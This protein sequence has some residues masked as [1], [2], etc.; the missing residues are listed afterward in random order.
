MT[1]DAAKKH[2]TLVGAEADSDE[3]RILEDAGFTVQIIPGQ[4]ASS[5]TGLYEERFKMLFTALNDG[6]FLADII[7]DSDGI[8]NDY[9]YV[10]VNPAFG[11]MVGIGSAQIIGK[12]AS[13]LL[14]GMTSSW[15]DVFR[16][17]APTNISTRAEIYSELS[18]RN[19]EVFAFKS[20]EGQYAAFVSDITFRKHAEDD[21]HKLNRTLKA[22]SRSDKAMMHA[23]DESE[24]MNDV[25]KIIIEDCGHAMVWIA[26]AENDEA[27]SV[28]PVAQAGFEEGYLENLNI[29]WADTERGQ[30]PTGTAIRTGMPCICKNMVSD[31]KFAAWRTEALKRGYASSISL[32]LKTSGQTFGAI[33]I[34]ARIPD[35]FSEDEA[36][37]LNELASD[38]AY[39]ITAIRLRASHAE[40]EV[41]LR[42]SEQRLTSIINSINHPFYALD[43]EWRFVYL[44][45]ATEKSL[46]MKRDDLIGRSIWDFWTGVPGNQFYDNLHTAMNKRMEIEFESYSKT[47]NRWV[48]ARV[49]PSDEGLT[50]YLNDITERKKIEDV[51]LFLLQRGWSTTDEDFFMSLA[52]FLADALEMD[53]V[54]IDKLAGDHLSAQTVAIYNDGKFEDNVSYTLKDTP[55]GDVVSNSI[56]CYPSGVMHLFPNDEVLQEMKADS[57]IGTTLWSSSGEPIGLIAVIGCKP[58]ENTRLAEAILKLTSIRAAGEL[59][60]RQAEEKLNEASTLAEEK[61]AQLESFITSL[62]DGVI[63]FDENGQILFMNEAGKTIFGISES[64]MPGSWWTYQRYK[65]SPGKIPLDDT[66]LYQ[67]LAGEIVR[68]FRYKASMPWG[69]EVTVSVSAAPVRD[70]QD[71]IMG[72]TNV[73]RDIS[74]LVE[75]E[76][77]KE[78]IYKREHKIAQILQD[79]IMPAEV[80]EI[81]FGC[82]IAAMYRPAMDEAQIGGD[83][84]D[85]FDLGDGKFGVLIGDV[86]GKGLPAAMR[87]AAARYAVRSYAYTD[88]RPSKVMELSNNSLCRDSGDEAKI[89]TAL[90]AIINTRVGVITYA[91]AGHEPPV[92]QKNSG[93]CKA[94]DCGGVPFGIFQGAEYP[95]V[96]L[97]LDPGDTIVLITDGITEA[98]APGPVLFGNQRMIDV[99]EVNAGA[100]PKEI[101]YALIDAATDHAGG[102]LQDD[103]AIVAI[104]YELDEVST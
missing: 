44:N 72:A 78:E 61:A 58:L 81:M 73:F 59:E 17:V 1:E 21:L 70:K 34:Y 82:H 50:V 75:F 95:Q 12:T 90:F 23:V 88:I 15:L 87:V 85:I 51:Y 37:L 45:K 28:R 63:L 14:P 57:Y 93:E 25:C 92:I 53:Y 35:A 65:L 3:V 104:R 22:L 96:S 40:A 2:V 41:S 54:C 100:M 11:Q 9:R 42:L 66:S 33:M 83:F 101:V 7:Y 99:I 64:E 60:R 102:S 4:S 48:D 19:F 79:A 47:L 67:A 30:G 16:M 76:R 5:E 32:P 62:A 24:Y 89:L 98:R 68:D 31:P 103:A 52:R 49:F 77:K 94:L 97:R 6:F 38:L 29:T 86:T 18:H 36:G 56:C 74:D 43:N 84:Y 27:K 55:C 8:P 91:T 80:P 71:R 20:L 46:G 10:D 26:F 69:K 13:E 39:G